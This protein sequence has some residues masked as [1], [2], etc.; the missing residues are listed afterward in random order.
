MRL[1]NAMMI[2]STQTA[3]VNT[4]KIALVFIS[5]FIRNYEILKDQVDGIKIP[6]AINNSIF[7]S[8]LCIFIVV[9]ERR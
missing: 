3:I 1:I 5:T 9:L 4:I 2:P 8:I 6:V 7:G